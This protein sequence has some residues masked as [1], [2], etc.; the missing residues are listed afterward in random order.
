VNYVNGHTVRIDIG[1][2]KHMRTYGEM[3]MAADNSKNPEKAFVVFTLL[4]RKGGV[5]QPRDYPECRSMKAQIVTL[6]RHLK[7]VFRMKEDPFFKYK[8]GV[9]WR[10]KFRVGKM[11]ED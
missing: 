2:A 1:D 4:A 6:R 5:V 3:G 10:A 9:G 7:R 11:E 8:K